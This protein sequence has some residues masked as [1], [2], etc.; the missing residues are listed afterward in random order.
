MIRE[1]KSK[2]YS[3]VFNTETGLLVRTVDLDKFNSYRGVRSPVPENLDIKCTDYCTMQCPS[4]YMDSTKE[5]L[6]TDADLI[7]QR[8]DQLSHYPYQVAIGGGE[9]NLYPQLPYLLQELRKRD[10]VPNYTTSGLGRS[11][12]LVDATNRF[13]GGISLSYHPH[14]GE[15]YFLDTYSWYRERLKVDL[16]IHVIADKN[17]ISSI[18]TVMKTGDPNLSIILLAYYPVGRGTDDY[19]MPHHIYN[20]ELP[21]F[22]SLIKD[23]VKIS[24]SEGLLPY[25]ISRPHILGS[26]LNSWI[27]S[28]S[29]FSAYMDQH[30]G[31]SKSSFNDNAWGVFNTGDLQKDWD[32]ISNGSSYSCDGGVCQRCEY[33][34]RCSSSNTHINHYLMCSKQRHNQ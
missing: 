26:E 9:P 1:M 2:G 12:A 10:I 4:C 14:K 22:L 28:E 33:R 27:R 18:Q 19:L 13:C 25:F 3:S 16:N 34:D 6:H 31:I 15:K 11:E 7:L 8:I 30:G 21:E 23:R 24:F 17:V 20:R 29:I 32:R 5:G